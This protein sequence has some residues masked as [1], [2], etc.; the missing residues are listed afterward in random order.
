MCKSLTSDTHRCLHHSNLL[1]ISP[2]LYFSENLI[3]LATR[4]QLQSRML[5][6]E[7]EKQLLLWTEIHP[8]VFWPLLGELLSWNTLCTL[9]RLVKEIFKPDIFS[10]MWS[11]FHTWTYRPQAGCNCI[12]LRSWTLRQLKHDEGS[13]YSTVPLGK[14]WK[15]Y[16]QLY[17]SKLFYQKEFQVQGFYKALYIIHLGQICPKNY[18]HSSVLFP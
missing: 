14:S 1:C 2:T 8:E 16:V 7:A 3:T 18:R 4:H 6:K 13:S 17:N 11:C 5:V 10:S 9:E 15:F 12:T